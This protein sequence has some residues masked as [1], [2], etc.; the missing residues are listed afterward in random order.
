[1]VRDIR[2][3]AEEIVRIALLEDL[4]TEGDV[5]T[6]AVLEEGATGKGTVVAREDCTV[7]GQPVAQAVFS[8][9]G[10]KASYTPF[11][12]DGEKAAAGTALGVVEG[13]LAS[14]LSCERTMLNFLSHMSGIAT[15]TSKFARLAARYGVEVMDTR[16]TTPGLRLLEKYAVA[17]AGGK[18]HRFGLFDGVIIKDNHIAAVGGIDIAIRR[19]RDFLGTR[20]PIEVEASTLSEV[21][22]ALENGA[23]IIM[24]DNMNPS[25]VEKAVQFI[26]KRARVEVSGGVNLENFSS[27]LGLGI[28]AISLGLLTHSAPAVDISLDIFF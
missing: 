25:E 7:A 13:D 27:Y 28:D 17:I 15:L 21:R 8:V 10:G 2:L 19:A 23:D 1:M 20:F 5:T 3:E 4:G 22:V 16:K 14:I 11:V 9:S 6:R 26:G 18:N 24:L 12:N